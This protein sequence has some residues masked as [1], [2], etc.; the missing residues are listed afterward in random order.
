[1]TTKQE[2]ERCPDCGRLKA[3]SADDCR[4]GMCPKWYAVRDKEMREECDAIAGFMRSRLAASG[5]EPVGWREGA[6]AAWHVDH[7]G[8]A[9]APEDWFRA[10]YAGVVAG[11]MQWTHAGK[12]VPLAEWRSIIHN[13]DLDIGD[14]L[15][16]LSARIDAFA[17]AP[18]GAPFD[19]ERELMDLVERA[20]SLVDTAPESRGQWY[21]KWDERAARFLTDAKRAIANINRRDRD[22]EG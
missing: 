21:A 2:Q 14:R 8:D 9:S 3:R 5:G 11:T 10:Y 22:A 7:P 1:M 17:A 15:Q 6:L 20:I 16:R 18:A 4:Y 12:Q 19:G 13:A